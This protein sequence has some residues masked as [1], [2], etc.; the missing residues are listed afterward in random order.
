M[1]QPEPGV[2]G[3]YWCSGKQGRAG[4]ALHK[5]TPHRDWVVV[6]GAEAPE[7]PMSDPASDLMQQLTGMLGDQVATQAKSAAATIRADEAEEILKLTQAA[8]IALRMGA[9]DISNAA[10]AKVRRLLEEP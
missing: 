7:E 4:C 10:L 3:C 9:V 5:A 2:V 8:E 6:E 1:G